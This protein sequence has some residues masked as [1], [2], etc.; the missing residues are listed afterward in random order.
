MSDAKKPAKTDKAEKSEAPAKSGKGK[1]FMII[2]IAVVLI[3]GGAGA[4][5]FMRGGKKDDAK[6]KQTAAAAAAAAP[7][8]APQYFK[9]DPAFVVNFAGDDGNR[10][11]QVA[12][13]AM[14]RDLKVSEAIKE[15]EPAIRNDM[16]LLLSGQKLEALNSAEGKE[17]LRA[18]ALETVRKVVGDE[19]YDGKLIEGVYFTSF[20]I[21]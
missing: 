11:L 5:F 19:G 20:V 7:K 12:M 17:T 10:Y 16:L 3:G 8:A 4:F 18:R 9:F 14:T 6:T 1:L 13:E 15:N 2:G 21:Q